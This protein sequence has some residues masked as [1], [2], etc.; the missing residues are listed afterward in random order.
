MKALVLTMPLL[1][2]TGCVQT[3]LPQSEQALD[4]HTFGV[5]SALEGKM[6]LSEARLLKLAEP[7]NLS[8]NLLASYQA[9]YQEGKQQYCQQ[10][11]YMLGVIGKP[12]YGI[13]D[14]V[15]PFFKQ[16]YLSGKMSTAGGL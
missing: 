15:D 5:E 10:N 2:L 4:W 11:A 12:Y 1:L 13:C 8:A 7:R 16:D 9:G 3:P 14:D 6:A